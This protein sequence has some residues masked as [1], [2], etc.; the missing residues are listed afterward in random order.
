[1]KKI[2]LVL[3]SAGSFALLTTSLTG[4]RGVKEG[5][6]E[7][8]PTK[9]NI[10]VATLDK[11]IG[12]EW[13]VN[14]AREFEELYKDSTE[15]EDGKTGVKVSIKGSDSLDG[16]YLQ[17]N[18]LNDDIYFTEG[19]AY[20]ELINKGKVLDIT[21]TVNEKLTAYGENKSIMDKIE[22]SLTDYLTVNGKIYGVP[23][24]DSFY[25][26]VYDMDL[27]N[28]RQLYISK[29]GQFVS[30]SGD[31]S[32]GTD[33][34]AGTLDDGLPATYEEFGK[35]ITKMKNKNITPYIC[36]NNGIEYTANYL[37]NIFADYEGL[38]N[39]RMN[40]TLS[41]TANDLINLNV[42]LIA[43]RNKTTA[44]G[45]IFNTIIQFL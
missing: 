15:F 45:R 43:G 13:L 28:E 9:A 30:K 37:Y 12:T 8:D 20:R 24:Y 6:D 10:V 22:D 19:I 11:G 44:I 7:Y 16:E 31:L 29:T 35:L 2:K 40:I 1:M 32:L 14:A 17:I 4:C 26:L 41:G 21:S 39:M 18:N 3:I 34:V 5:E 33:H 42:I 25:G 23:F 38:D 36:S 27:W